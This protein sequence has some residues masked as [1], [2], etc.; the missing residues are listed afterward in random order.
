[1]GWNNTIGIFQV[2][3]AAQIQTI[4]RLKPRNL[5]DMAHELDP[6]VAAMLDETAA[7]ERLFPAVLG[8]LQRA[9]Y[10]M[11]LV[12]EDIHWA[13]NATLDLIKYLGRRVPA[14]R[15]MLVLSLRSDEIVDSLSGAGV[16][17]TISAPF[18]RFAELKRMT[19]ARSRWQCFN[20]ETHY[21]EAS[22]KPNCWR[23]RHRFLFI[24]T[25]VKKQ[26]KGPLQL[27]LF[28]PCD[29]AY[30]YKVVVTNK[31]AGALSIV[32][33]HEGRGTQENV[34][35]ELKSHCHLDYVPVRTLCGNQMYL[36]A[37]LFAYNLTRELQMRTDARARGTTPSRAALWAF[38][39]VDTL[40]K[41]VLQ[42][43]GRLSRPGGTLTLTIADGRWLRQRIGELLG[44]AVAQP[45]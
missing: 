18:E 23:R 35:G 42:R 45:G 30:E 19:E 38:E 26:Q 43:A 31:E 8:A 14:L 16:E 25:S 28:V 17:F 13:D 4:V 7:P 27:D 44:G 15:T 41:T 1:M 37:G 6:R 10:T 24:R 33:Y 20:A 29:Y 2:E 40:R 11:V 9:R 21:F 34:F 32:R 12:L 22:W 36:L 5:L 39:K 3:S